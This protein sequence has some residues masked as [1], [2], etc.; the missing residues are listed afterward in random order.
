MSRGLEFI[1]QCTR[2]GCHPAHEHKVK[3]RI[4]SRKEA[5]ARFPRLSN[6]ASRDNVG[7][8]DEEDTYAGNRCNGF[9]W[10]TA[11]SQAADLPA[12]APVM[13]LPPPFTWTG[14]YLG[15]NIGAAWGSRSITDDTTGV[16]FSNSSDARFIGGGQVGFN[17]QFGMFVLGAEADFDF[18]TNNSNN[19][20]GVVTPGGTIVA[21]LNDTWITTAAARLGLAFDHFLF[22]GKVGGGW[23]GSNNFT[24]QNTTTGGVVTFGNNNSRSGFLGGVGLEYAVTNNWT[25]KG[26][27]D[28]LS[29]DNRTFVVPVGSPFLVGDSFTTRNR[30][31]QMFK[32]GFNYL[33]H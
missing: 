3:W 26:E 2:L 21:R 33:F 31:V 28:F 7:G 20:A 4:I 18:G 24:L 14:F 9:S 1:A 29:L 19:G 12:R 11:L 22:Y 5:H 27:Y 30:N 16:T 10:G 23:V 6:C 8:L 25:V 15:G 32:A 13:P 17:Y